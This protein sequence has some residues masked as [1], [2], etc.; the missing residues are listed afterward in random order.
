MKRTTSGFT[1]VEV[2]VSLSLFTVVVTMS[3]GTMLVLIDANGKQ[4]SMQEVMTNLSFALDSMTREIRTGSFYQCGGVLSDVDNTPTPRDC[5]SGASSFAFTESGDGLTAGTGS[6]RIAYGLSNNS[7]VRRLGTGQWQTITSPEVNIT[8]LSFVVTDTVQ[9]I[10][11]NLKSPTV[12]IFVSGTAGVISGLD[13]SFDIQ[14][15]LTQQLLDL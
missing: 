11:G 10:S 14:T 8:E 12:T 3:V 2:L 15:T 9:Q 6:N 13:S 5:V 4:Q 7:I 1:L